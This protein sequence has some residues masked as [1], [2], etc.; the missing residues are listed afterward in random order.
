MTE[1]DLMA[2]IEILRAVFWMGSSLAKVV[3]AVDP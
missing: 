1:E 3:G 2:P